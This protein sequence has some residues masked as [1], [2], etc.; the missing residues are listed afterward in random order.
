[1][2]NLNSVRNV[3]A[4]FRL[5]PRIWLK[6]RT[7]SPDGY[8]TS[9]ACS[10]SSSVPS[11][12]SS[13]ASSIARQTSHTAPIARRF[14]GDRTRKACA[15]AGFGRHRHTPSGC[16]P[17][18]AARAARHALAIHYNNRGVRAYQLHEYGQA[19]DWFELAL[20]QDPEFEEAST[21]LARLYD[22]GLR[23]MPELGGADKL[24]KL[25]VPVRTLISFEGH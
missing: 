3:A 17:L 11:G 9:K 19:G 24:R 25:N 5:S 18:E 21:S 16:T 15:A 1:M 7:S 14:S 22:Q 8:R 2:P 10:R 4:R 6:A 23:D 12:Y 20:Q 13:T